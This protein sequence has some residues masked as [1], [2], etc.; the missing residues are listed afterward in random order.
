[1]LALA[2]SG[3]HDTASPH[4]P[5]FFTRP[6]VVGL[7]GLAGCGKST[8]AAHLSRTHGYAR[9]RFADPLKKGLIAMG[10]SPDEIDGALKTLPSDFF[11][12]KTP[13]EAMQT[14]GTEWGRKMIG[15]NFWVN[16]WKRAVDET[17]RYRHVVAEDARF[18]NEAT[19]IHNYGGLLVLVERPGLALDAKVGSHESERYASTLGQDATLINDGSVEDLHRAIDALLTRPRPVLSAK[20]A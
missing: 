7:S 12:E 2:P 1:M 17:L 19:A 9:V 11:C 20:A 16:A 13:R 4:I 3:S 15:Q 18:P 10:A 5:P 6:R 8:V 14:I